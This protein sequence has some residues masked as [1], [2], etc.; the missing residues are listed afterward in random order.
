[1]GNTSSRSNGYNPSSAYPREPIFLSRSQSDRHRARYATGRSRSE[2][3]H[4]SEMGYVSGYPQPAYTG[5]YQQYPHQPQRYY[6]QPQQY[7]YVQPALAPQVAFPQQPVIP[8]VPG[9]GAPNVIPN[10]PPR[11]AQAGYPQQGATMV[12]PEPVI[13]ST[14]AHNENAPVIPQM[15][16]QA[17][18]PEP[19]TFPEPEYQST[20]PPPEQRGR[21]LA[22]GQYGLYDRSARRPHSPLTNPLPTPPKDIFELSPYMGLLE[23]LRRP[24][25][26]TTLKR[27]F[28]FTT[29]GT[30]VNLNMGQDYNTS[31]R[32]SHDKRHRKGLLGMFGSQRRRQEDEDEDPPVMHSQPAIYASVPV[33]QQMPDGSTTYVYNPP[34]QMGQLSTNSNAMPMPSATP[35]PEPMRGSTPAPVRMHT[36]A[37]AA[38]MSTPVPSRAPIIKVDRGNELAGLLHFS[39]H[40]VHFEQK[41]YPSAFHLLEALKFLGHRPDIAERIRTCG[42]MDEV[43]VLVASAQEHVRRDWSQVMRQMMDEVLYHKF[44]QHPNIRALLMGTGVAQLVFSDLSDPFWG[45]GS[46]GQGAN[47]L[48]KALVRVRDRLRAEGYGA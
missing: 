26:E 9:T 31:S 29:P 42:S 20:A 41:E 8:N 28:T 24:I 7:Q 39:P 5:G 17:S 46:L 25:D 35:V 21:R 40:S 13:P 36:P 27:S 32:R 38:R 23:S 19:V 30:A 2:D 43:G 18:M 44:V 1:M 48:G 3:W 4:P 11:T 33:M 16:Q 12:M 6:T 10:V 45:D 22:P 34:P 47:E 37:P 15:A 14:T